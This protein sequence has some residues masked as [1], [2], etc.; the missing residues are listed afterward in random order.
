MCTVI[1]AL[2]LGTTVAQASYAMKKKT[3]NKLIFFGF[4]QLEA[5]G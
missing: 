4:T 2:L 3:G 1:I 5:V